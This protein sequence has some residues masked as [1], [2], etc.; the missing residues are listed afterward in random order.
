MNYLVLEFSATS[1][2]LC[3]TG[4]DRMDYI[5]IGLQVATRTR[6]IFW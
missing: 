3:N 5:T 2:M 6:E 4:G 1:L